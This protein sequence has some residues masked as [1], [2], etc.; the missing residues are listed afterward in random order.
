MAIQ[1]ELFTAG[2]DMQVISR[3]VHRTARVLASVLIAGAVTSS[4]VTITID[5]TTTYQTIVGFGGSVGGTPSQHVGTLMNDGAVSVLR[6]DWC[7]VT[8]HNYSNTKACYDAATVKP[9]VVGSCW[10]P[11]AHMKDNNNLNNGG[12]LLSQYYDDFADYTVQKLQQFRTQYGVEMYALSPQNEPQ[13]AV[14]YPSCVYTGADLIEVFRL[15]GQK[16]AEAGLTTKLFLP[17]DMYD[18]WA[19]SPFFGPLMQDPVAQSYV[20]ALAFHGYSADGVTPAEMNAGVLHN[21][22]RQTSG[23]NWQLWQTENAGSMGMGWARDVIGCL[24]YGKLS[25]YLKYSLYGDS[26][27]MVGSLEEYYIC[28][29]NRT[30]THYV[31]KTI[32]KFI[33]RGSVQLK[34]TSPDSAT[35]GSF[36]A[37]RDPA[38]SALAISMVTGSQAQQVQIQ[39]TNLPATFELWLTNASTNCVNQGSQPSSA[40]FNIPANSVATLYGTGY[41]PP[42]VHVT[43]RAEFVQRGESALKTAG[44]YRIDGRSLG[45]AES[46]RYEGV[47]IDRREKLSGAQSLRRVSVD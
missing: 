41:N 26:P 2:G 22:Y 28:Q 8:G 18:A 19:N 32:S 15:T 6:V 45:T 24:K 27:G 20:H 34:S 43:R 9:V 31:A 35:F 39:G 25:M 14:F 37:F 36:V 4:A 30:L 33:P 10:S 13:F 40:T 23:K 42:A 7:E 11:P 12:H 21:M 5:H 3:K 29:G 17:E 16:I 1:G 47:V 38:Q 44:V 46:A